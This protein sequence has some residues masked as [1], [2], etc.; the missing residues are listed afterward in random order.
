MRHSLWLLL[1]AVLS[2]PAQAGTEYRDIHDR[3]LRRI[4]RI[5]LQR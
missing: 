3:G 1:A 5:T 4:R 2:L